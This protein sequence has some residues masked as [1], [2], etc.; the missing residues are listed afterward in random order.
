MADKSQNKI[1][2]KKGCLKLGKVKV[3]KKNMKTLLCSL[4]AVLLLVSCFTACGPTSKAQ[5]EN[6]NNGEEMFDGILAEADG[7]TYGY[8][9]GEKGGWELLSYNSESKKLTTHG[10]TDA[11]V[12]YD[13]TLVFGP[14]IVIDGKVYVTTT[15]SEREDEDVSFAKKG[16]DL[17]AFGG[18]EYLDY[19][20]LFEENVVVE[21]LEEKDGSLVV[22]IEDAEAL[23]EVS[24]L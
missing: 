16:V 1:N 3:M 21:K 8:K 4:L 10:N 5:V 15:C 12:V 2:Y 9:K 19:G 20:K 23:F 24:D 18:E 17:F 22:Y 11:Y 6:V 7:V 14:S 13:K